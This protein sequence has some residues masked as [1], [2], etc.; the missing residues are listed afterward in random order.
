MKRT[1]WPFRVFV[2]ARIEESWVVPND[3]VLTPG[4][5]TEWKGAKSLDSCH[6]PSETAEWKES[7]ERN[8]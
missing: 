6:T 5:D 4:T 7:E 1:F 2:R 3:S 8:N